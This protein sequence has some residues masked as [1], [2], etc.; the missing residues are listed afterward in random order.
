MEIHSSRVSVRTAEEE[1]S[2]A[3]NETQANARNKINTTNPGIKPVFTFI[4]S[5]SSRY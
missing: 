5:P 1:F 3:G 4:T 2:S